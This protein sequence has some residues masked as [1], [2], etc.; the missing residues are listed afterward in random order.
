MPGPIQHAPELRFGSRTPLLHI[1]CTDPKQAGCHERAPTKR[2]ELLEKHVFP[3]M[4]EPLRYSPVFRWQLEGPQVIQHLLRSQR[5][6]SG[7]LR[8]SR[9]NSR[10]GK[11][12]GDD[13]KGQPCVSFGCALFYANPRRG[14]LGPSNGP[15]W[16]LISAK[17]RFVPSSGLPK[18]T[19]QSV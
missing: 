6:R 3:A 4:I 2:R 7:V 15:L 1:R 13:T 12:R 19:G 5:P 17:T 8:I 14:M 11:Y 16:Q 10:K 18:I 9:E